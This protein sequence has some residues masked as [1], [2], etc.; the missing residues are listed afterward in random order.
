MKASTV[1]PPIGAPPSQRILVIED[2]ASMCDL[3]RILLQKDGYTVAS[4]S[5]LNEAEQCLS[6]GE[7]DL[8]VTDLWLD[9][10]KDGGIRVLRR[11]Q[12]VAPCTPALVITAHGSV[13]SAID[14]MKLGAFDYLIK[15][16]N[17]DEL[18]LMVQKA[19]EQSALKRENR[20][21]VNQLRQFNDLDNI[22]GNSAAML[23]VKDMIRRVG[24]LTSTVLV[25]G[26][27]GTGKELV[28]RAIHSCSPRSAGPFLSINCGGLP[29]TLLESEL[30]GHAKGSFTGAIS[31]KIGLFQAADGGTLFLDE[32]GDTSMA[33]QVKLLRTL[34]DM[35]IRPVGTNEETRVDVRLVSAT[36]RDLDAMVEAGAFR[37]DFFYRLN[38]IPIHLPPLRERHAD[39]PIL[40]HHFLQRFSARLGK[41]VEGLAP[42]AMDVLGQYAWPGNIRE[43]E[44]IMERTIALC[45]GPTIT[46]EDLPSHL[47]RPSVLGGRRETDL[48][49]DG[50]DLE[51]KVAQFEQNLLSQ[52]LM[53]ANHSQVKAA[54]LLGLSPRS[55]RYKLEKYNMKP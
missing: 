17:N 8:V 15:P 38:V 11:L 35:V 48:P 34:S 55:L 7:W 42:D 50:I 19:L 51:E 47:T 5:T 14:A 33:L 22:I 43:F 18:R 52:A 2:E 26:E 31:D 54:K 36:N 4:A 39:I 3:L 12:E 32:I 30:F 41:P 9:Q 23:E 53:M 49:P 29:D 21:L 28:A 10:V 16:F 44:N 40:A 20:Q 27:S 25:L 45:H 6:D 13:N 24:A 46:V 1:T 37:E